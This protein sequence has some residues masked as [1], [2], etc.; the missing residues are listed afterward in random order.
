MAPQPKSKTLIKAFHMVVGCDLIGA[1]SSL[2][3][4]KNMTLEATPYGVKAYSAS[5]K[6]N[7]LIPWTN[8]KGC[9]LFADVPDSES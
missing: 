8:V 2:A 1:K 3:T 5:S 4:S 6:R 9:E 7:I